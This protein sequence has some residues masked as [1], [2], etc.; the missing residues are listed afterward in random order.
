MCDEIPCIKC[1]YFVNELCMFW[2]TYKKKVNPNDPICD[3]FVKKRV[4]PRSYKE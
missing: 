1:V 4:V 3:N 2:E